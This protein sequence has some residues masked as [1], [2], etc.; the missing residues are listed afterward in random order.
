[1]SV[2]AIIMKAFAVS[3]SPLK[4]LLSV[5]NRIPR[6]SVSFRRIP[7]PV[8]A[9]MLSDTAFKTLCLFFSVNSSTR[10]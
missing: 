1:M 10:S 7:N 9:V 5:L 4:I 3:L 6:P 8:K 2:L